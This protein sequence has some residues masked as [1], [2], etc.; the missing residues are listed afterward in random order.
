MD[1]LRK[2]NGDSWFYNLPIDSAF[3]SK[4]IWDA[5]TALGFRA[6]VISTNLPQPVFRTS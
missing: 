6:P 1:Q 2:Q 5:C 4:W 3:L